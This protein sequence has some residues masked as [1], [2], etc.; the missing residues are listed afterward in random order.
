MSEWVYRVGLS[1]SETSEDALKKVGLVYKIV[2]PRAQLVTSA[3]SAI[4]KPYKRGASVLKDAQ[5]GFDCSS[6][7]AWAA[8]EAGFS[9]PRVTVDQYV[10]AKKINR[11]EM[12]PGDL[13]FVNTKRIVHTEGTYFSQVL[14]K[15]VSEEPIRYETLEYMPGTKVPEGI[16]HVGIYVGDDQIIHATSSKGGVVEE[17]L[18]ESESFQEAL[19]YGRIINNEG[20]RYVIEIPAGRPDLRKKEALIDYLRK[21]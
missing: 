19:H 1:Q 3:K 13:I 18:N 6:L 8:V 14:G 11:D 17:N 21:N 7:V 15:E 16:D 5:N 2:E 9:I 4:G 20:Q 10:F 12:L